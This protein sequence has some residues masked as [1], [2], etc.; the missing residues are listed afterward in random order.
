[1]TRVLGFLD[2]AP[3]ARPAENEPRPVAR[4][5]PE[6]VPEDAAAVDVEGRVPPAAHALDDLDSEQR[7]LLPVEPADPND[8]ERLVPA[9]V[10]MCRGRQV[11]QR[12]RDVR[13]FD[14]V[15]PARA[16]D[17]RARQRDRQRQSQR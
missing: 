4:E 10:T 16:S 3:A 12:V 6:L 15:A 11:P 1:M 17:P 13:G 7:V 2:L 8:P 9:E 14:A 5:L